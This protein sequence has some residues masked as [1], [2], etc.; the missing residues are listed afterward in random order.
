MPLEHV[1]LNMLIN[2]LEKELNREMTVADDSK[3]SRAKNVICQ[4]RAA[5]DLLTLNACI[6]KLQM[7]FNINNI[8]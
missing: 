5:K 4:E 2:G 3:S 6:I 7:K 8:K 1:L